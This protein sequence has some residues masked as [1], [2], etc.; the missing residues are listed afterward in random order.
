[1]FFCC[2]DHRARPDV[3]S[4]ERVGSAMAFVAVAVSLDLAGSRTGV[5]T[6]GVRRAVGRGQAVMVPSTVVNVPAPALRRA[7]AI[8]VRTA[9]S[10]CAAHMA[11]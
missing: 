6:H 11:R 4:G 9:A 1:M 3:E 2:A 8:T 7:V 5:I 10:P